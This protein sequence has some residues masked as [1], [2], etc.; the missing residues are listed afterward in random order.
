MEHGHIP[1]CYVSL[2]ETIPEKT[3]TSTLMIWR[4]F[5]DCP[6]NQP[7]DPPKQEGVEVLIRH[8]QFFRI[9]F[10]CETVFEDLD[11]LIF[12]C[13]GGVTQ[14]SNKCFEYKR[15]KQKNNN[16]LF[17]SFLDVICLFLWI[18]RREWTFHGDRTWGSVFD[19]P[20]KHLLRWKASP[21]P[22]V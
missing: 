14:K 3:A 19:H 18:R 5:F 12:F 21:N 9:L 7:L 16:I 11:L 17:R 22:K 13:V 8:S 15:N 6:K 1:A 2:P 4:I 10:R 20:T